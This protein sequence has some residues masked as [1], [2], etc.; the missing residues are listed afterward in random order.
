[1][2]ARPGQGLLSVEWL[3]IQDA[4][5]RFE[6]GR[7]L[8]PGQKYPGLGLLRDTVAV[9]VILSER[10][11]LDGLV[12][13]PSHFHLAALSRPLAVNPDRPIDRKEMLQHVWGGNTREM[14]TRT[15]DMHIRRLREKLERDPTSPEWIVTVR[16]KGY[17][18]A[19]G[20]S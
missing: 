8:L 7:A 4:R 6:I 15:V 5:S 16:N 9:L 20:A 11:D 14:E 18:F 2:A 3:L 10:L 12:F 1:M 17:M 13:T 19:R